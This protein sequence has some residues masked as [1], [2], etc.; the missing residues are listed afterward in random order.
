M[1]VSTMSDAELV[2]AKAMAKEIIAEMKRLLKKGFHDAYTAEISAQCDAIN[3]ISD[4]QAR[5]KAA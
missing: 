2:A 4:E 3:A 1:N 5:R